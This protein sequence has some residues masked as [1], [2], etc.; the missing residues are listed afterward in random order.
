MKYELELYKKD[1][2]KTL[3]ILEAII[4]RKF[5]KK[6]IEILIIKNILII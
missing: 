5:V 4:M 3:S 2:E 1:F 6:L